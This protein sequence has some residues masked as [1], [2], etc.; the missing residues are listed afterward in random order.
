MLSVPFENR[1]IAQGSTVMIHDPALCVCGGKKEFESAIAEFNVV[2]DSIA[3]IYADE[4]NLSKEQSLEFMSAETYFSADEAVSSGFAN[5][6]NS[7]K[8]T[9]SIENIKSFISNVKQQ[10]AIN[11]V[12]QK[13]VL[14]NWLNYGSAESKSKDNQGNDMT[15]EEIKVLQDQNAVLNSEQKTKDAQIQA[16]E[17][18]I[19]EVEDANKAIT[20][21]RDEALGN[22]ESASAN[23]LEN[24]KKDMVEANAAR[25][26]AENVGFKEIEGDTLQQVQRNV[27]TAAKVSKP[28]NFEGEQL[29]SM[30]DFVLNSREGSKSDDDSHDDA[31]EGKPKDKAVAFKRPSPKGKN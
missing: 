21:E 17:S 16:L 18:R 13:G 15:P 6:S 31:F 26:S 8:V 23:A 22:I 27:L 7:N 30:F 2:S 28:E 3:S 11:P 25:V 12:E 20:A 10:C 19:K 9:T 1:F 4:T 14:S 24:V 29:A 5:L